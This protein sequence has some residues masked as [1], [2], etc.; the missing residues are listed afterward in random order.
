MM[1]APRSGRARMWFGRL[2]DMPASISRMRP[3]D[4]H[5]AN[6]SE[7]QAHLCVT[8]VGDSG[9]I[10]PQFHRSAVLEVVQIRRSARRRCGKPHLEFTPLVDVF[11]RKYAR[12][13]YCLGVI[14][15]ASFLSEHIGDDVFAVMRQ[16]KMQVRN[17]S[18]ARMLG[19]PLVG[20]RELGLPGAETL[21]FEAR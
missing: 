1:S 14:R 19:A 2:F 20:K 9:A 5:D 4:S 21:L 7:A 6:A 11:A 18:R 16:A 15:A 10:H 3:C 13:T 17:G 8:T 12:R